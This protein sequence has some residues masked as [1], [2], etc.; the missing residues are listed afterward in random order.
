[1]S[2]EI[3]EIN[4]VKFEVDLSTAKKIQEF[5]VGDSVKILKKQ[6]QDYKA[7]LGIIVGFDWFESLPTVRIA[8]LDIDYSKAEVNFIDYNSESKDIEISPLNNIN[9]LSYNRSTI[10]DLLNRD[11]DKRTIE[12]E[13]MKQK[14]ELFI[15]TFAKYFEESK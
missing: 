14:K 12:L 2:K 9:E 13:E 1:M 8:Y 11:I 10:I 15:N 5:K 7:S 4:G 3:V 6:Y